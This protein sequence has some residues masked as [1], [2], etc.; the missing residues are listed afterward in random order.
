MNRHMYLENNTRFRF[1]A[2]IQYRPSGQQ[3]LSQTP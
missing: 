2:T 3:R 1:M